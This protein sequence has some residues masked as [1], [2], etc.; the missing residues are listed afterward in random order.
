MQARTII[1]TLSLLC[2]TLPVAAQQSAEEKPKRDWGKLSGSVESSWGIYMKDS[3]LGIDQLDQTYGTNTYVNLGYAIK[4]FRFGLQ[5][6]IFEKPMIGYDPMLEGNGLRGGF[7]AWANSKW[8]VTL[9]TYVEQ[10]GSGLILRA[11]DERDMGINTSLL[12]GNLH[13]RPA[14]WLST[15]FVVGKPRR[16]MSFADSWVYGA[17]AELSL[18][19]LIAPQSDAMLMVGGSWVLRDDVSKLH[20]EEY[21]AAVNAFSGR[22]DFTKGIFSLGGEYVR[23]GESMRVD[24]RY[25]TDKGVGQGL[26]L[27]AGF[28]LPGFG[29]SAVWRSIESLAWRQEDVSEQGVSTNLNYIPSL[30]KQHKYALCS[31]FPHKMNDYGGETGGQ[32][33]IFGEIP[34]G[35]HPRRPLSFAVNASMYKDMERSGSHYKFMGMGGDLSFAEASLELEKKWGPDWKTI[36]VFAYQ[37][38]NEFSRYGFGE[39]RMNTEIVVADVLWQITNKTSLR[40]ELQHAWSDSYDDQRWMMGLLELGIAPKWMVYVSDMCNYQSYGDNIHYFDAGVS[41][42]YKFLRAG[43]SFGRYRAGEVCSGG[44]CRYVPEHTGVNIKLSIIL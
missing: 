29:M 15:K 35:E 34:V 8:E 9:G 28:D 22:L 14:S 12:G 7:A 27:N 4:G 30:T 17:D 21:P 11:Y 3:A 31:L 16:F 32:I 6:D 26:L 20:P 42:A 43:V 41:Y 37:R 44:I 1:A 38:Q 24:P 23:R 25:G 33:D 2:A 40:A 10:F 19:E 13:W 18:L 36:L 5:Y 39:M